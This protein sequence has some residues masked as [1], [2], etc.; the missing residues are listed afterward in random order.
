MTELEHDLK[1]LSYKGYIIIDLLLRN[2]P[3][4]RLFKM[5]FDGMK[6]DYTS[7]KK[8]KERDEN[9][10]LRL[11]H[12]YAQNLNWLDNGTLFES[13]KTEIEERLKNL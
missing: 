1:N 9:L 8:I 7:M 12:V 13:T 2:G 4:D 11:D 6:M 10:L 5:F 3:N